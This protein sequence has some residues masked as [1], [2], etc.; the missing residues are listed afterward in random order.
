MNPKRPLV[1]ASQEVIEIASLAAPK[2]PVSCPSLILAGVGVQLPGTAPAAALVLVE[3][4]QPEHVFQ[5][6]D[7]RLGQCPRFQR[8]QGHIGDLGARVPCGNAAGSCAS[9]QVM[10]PDSE[11]RCALTVAGARPSPLEARVRWSRQPRTSRRITAE[12]L[13]W[14]C[15]WWK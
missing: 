13:S 15:S 10:N 12:S 3:A 9:T 2:H 7:L 1:R 6:P 8:W 5:R 4:L 14:P 11:E